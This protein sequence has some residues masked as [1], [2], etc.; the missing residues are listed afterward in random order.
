ME[1]ISHEYKINQSGNLISVRIS[2]RE[3]LCGGFGIAVIM[4]GNS[5]R[6]IRH[7][8]RYAV[9]PDFKRI[10]QYIY[11]NDVFFILTN[12]DGCD[13]YIFET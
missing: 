12:A 1:L 7:K 8:I 3:G 11:T 6:K 10:F 4:D 9:I 13:A 2:V 5:F